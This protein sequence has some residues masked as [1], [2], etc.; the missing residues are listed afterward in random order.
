[1]CTLYVAVFVLLWFF[2]VS[3][4]LNCFYLLVCILCTAMFIANCADD[5]IHLKAAFVPIAF[6]SVVFSGYL[7]VSPTLVS[8]FKILSCDLV[9]RRLKNSYQVHRDNMYFMPARNIRIIK[10]D[11]Y[12]SHSDV[13]QNVTS[14]ICCVNIGLGASKFPTTGKQGLISR[15][16]S[17]CTPALCL[18]GRDPWQARACKTQFSHHYHSRELVI[19]VGNR[20][21]RENLPNVRC[22][23][24]PPLAAHKGCL[25]PDFERF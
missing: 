7:I 2:I 23:L 5:S 17:L 8:I 24:L 3:D 13:F 21:K 6:C 4:S 9:I 15:T 19:F 16:K 11:I 18:C 10:L 12:F 14:A 25:Y 22:D 1:M 20:L